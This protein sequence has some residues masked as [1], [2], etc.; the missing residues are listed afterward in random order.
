MKT[1]FIIECNS[2][3]CGTCTGSADSCDISCDSSC[4]ECDVAGKCLNCLSG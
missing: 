1:T 4:R 2:R 3:V